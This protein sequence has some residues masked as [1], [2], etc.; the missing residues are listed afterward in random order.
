M[1]LIALKCKSED[2]L[3]YSAI[4]TCSNNLQMMQ[5]KIV[6]SPEM[7]LH[8]QY[9][10]WSSDVTR[11]VP[12][13]FTGDAVIDDGEEIIY[14]LLSQLGVLDQIGMFVVHGFQLQDLPKFSNECK[15]EVPAIL[16]K[17]G[18]SD[19]IIFHHS[20]GLISIE[21]INSLE[22]DRTA[23]MKAED[24]LE[25]S[26]D[27]VAK[28][29]AY[30]ANNGYFLPHKKIIALPSS[31][32]PN[33]VHSMH[34]VLV[35]TREN[36]RD[37]GAFQ[38][39]WHD[40]LLKPHPILTKMSGQEAYQRALSYTLLIHHLGPVTETDFM[41]YFNEALVSQKYNFFLKDTFP[42]LWSWYREILGTK[43]K[44]FQYEKAENELEAFIEKHHLKVGELSSVKTFRVI[45]SILKQSKYISGAS[46]C[47]ID[48]ILALS[49][50]DINTPFFIFKELLRFTNDVWQARTQITK[51]TAA[52]RL[53]LREKYPFLKLGSLD[54]LKVLN[55]HLKKF[56]FVNGDTPNELDKE[57]F[58]TLTCR[59][60]MK[61]SRLPMIMTP[62]QLTVFEGPLK[63]IIIGPPGSGKT[64]LMKFKALE[65]E[66]EMKICK[67]EKRILFILAN[68]NPEYLN[69]DSL[70]YYHIQEFFKTSSLVDV[71]TLSFD[72]DFKEELEKTVKNLRERIASGIYEHAFVD[73]YWIGSKPDE[74]MILKELVNGIPGYVWISSVHDYSDNPN[75][76]KK[77]L[78]RTEPLVTT[79]K[80]NG[81]VVSRITKV[82]RATNTIVNL[83]RS[84]IDE[85]EHRSYIF[86]T[87]EVLE[88]SFKGL[89]VTWEVA[90]D[91]AG[92]Y[93]KC[94]DIVAG[95]TGLSPS[96]VLGREVLTLYPDDVLVVNFAIRMA[97][98]MKLD[99][100]LEDH[101]NETG[102]P[103][104]TFEDSL[105]DFEDCGVKKVS[106]VE[107]L[108]RNISCYIDG[109][110]WP[111]VVVILPHDL[112]MQK[113][114]LA[115]GA[116]KLRNYDIFISFFRAMVK[117]VIISD[118]WNNSEEFL[119]DLAKKSRS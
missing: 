54:D 20:L 16:S 118:K 49:L 81:G 41:S 29:A 33:F 26:H 90:K 83:E 1:S 86:G 89:P 77:I 102:L 10:N 2:I 42:E 96:R 25:T 94:T 50:A 32:A 18:I 48:D 65:L 80:E 63:Q 55:R 7:F 13:K 5:A 69:K 3:F 68:G 97:D 4:V 57:L 46:R 109:V 70:L 79:I 47:G 64:E 82:L 71:I 44:H 99:H 34:D 51:Q 115:T 39:W 91:I 78:I 92:M 14:K 56:T 113:A 108:V 11:M 15:S 43:D 23:L 112:M 62:D 8:K 119:E 104:W 21:V 67:E 38:R 30:D 93:L 117:L 66:F 59:T 6:G 72:G 95:A 24:K 88:N 17:S 87:K 98:S 116:E 100:S 35:L 114:K 61:H 107:S 76:K 45:N 73:E 36:S 27:L 85:Y 106:L 31:D 105:E 40:E 58:E 74:H 52:E 12:S 84:Y 19:F 28:L 53:K 103:V 60:R 22:V 9:P 111:M 110:E 75:H 37:I 101:L